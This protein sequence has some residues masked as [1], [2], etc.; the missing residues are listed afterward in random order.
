MSTLNIR[1]LIA[2]TLAVP[3][4]LMNLVY[5]RSGSTS[6]CPMTRPVID[7]RWARSG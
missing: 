2:L 6:D 7:R 4:E 1:V 5:S 3:A